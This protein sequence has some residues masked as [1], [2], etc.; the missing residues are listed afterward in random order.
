MSEYFLKDQLQ[1]LKDNITSI[2]F[3]DFMCKFQDEY[4]K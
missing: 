1:R 2:Q 4:Q 3:L